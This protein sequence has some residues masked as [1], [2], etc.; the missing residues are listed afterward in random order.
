MIDFNTQN[1]FELDDSVATTDWLH[2]II[3]NEG[4]ILGDLGY[5]FCDDSFL[6]SINIE[7]L[8]HDTLTDVISF[9]YTSS[10]IIGG[11]IY[12]STERVKDNA[13]DLGVSFSDELDRVIVHGLLHFCGYGDKSDAEKVK[14]RYLEDYY[15]A[16]RMC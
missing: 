2:N 8:H 9:D 1:D 10:N 13:I 4:K 5:V 16:Q 7:F 6:H 15:L 14:M 12:I 11:E 3:L